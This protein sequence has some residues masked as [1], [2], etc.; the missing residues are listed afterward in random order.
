MPKAKLDR[1]GQRWDIDFRV[2]SV[3]KYLMDK[4]QQARRIIYQLGQAVAGA[5]VDGML[6]ETSSVPT[7]VSA[8]LLI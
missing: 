5:G 1:M 6:K 2:K 4:V 8:P 7:I 3:R